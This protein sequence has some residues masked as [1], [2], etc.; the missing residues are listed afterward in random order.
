MVLSFSS[1]GPI[2]KQ[3]MFYPSLA[4]TKRSECSKQSG[5]F[6]VAELNKGVREKHQNCMDFPKF[7]CKFTQFRI[8]IVK[9][10]QGWEWA[11]TVLYARIGKKIP[12]YTSV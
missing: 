6:K 3:L 9:Y 11:Y 4:Q 2:V 12:A 10:N 8:G 7:I 5:K 1:V